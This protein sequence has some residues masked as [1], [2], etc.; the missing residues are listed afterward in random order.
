MNNQNVA[1]LVK[2]LDSLGF[3]NM[4]YPLLKRICFKPDSFCLT[5][6]VEKGIEQ[7][8]FNLFI[9]KKGKG[10]EYVLIY[11][12]AI[13]QNEVMLTDLAL[14]GVNPLSL[15]KRMAEINWKKAF[16]LDE[17]TPWNI[18][19]KSDWENEMK[20]EA[21]ITDLIK[22]GEADEG[23]LI[24]SSLKMKHWVGTGYVELFDHLTTVKNKTEVSQRFYFVEG[25]LG[26]SIDE[27]IR[28]LQNK[29]LEKQMQAKRKQLEKPDEV[30][31]EENPQASTG[32]GLL[33]KRRIA[34]SSKHKRNKMIQD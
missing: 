24:A 26:I 2:Q 27:A 31:P 9:E 18:N 8:N 12:D 34:N 14:N 3:E 33:K 21:I 11:Y 19:E 1:A 22:L 17:R 16:E 4:S 23:K 10:E 20:I 32:S 7:F 30:D 15:D 29:W 6:R 13:L 25:Q 28:F 5:Y